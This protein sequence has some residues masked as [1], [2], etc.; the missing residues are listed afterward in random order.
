MDTTWGQ[1]CLNDWLHL[2]LAVLC[3]A[4]LSSA[5]LIPVTLHH[6]TGEIGNG[7]LNE[8]GWEWG[9]SLYQVN[10]LSLFHEG[11]FLEFDLVLLFETW[12]SVFLI[13][14]TL[15]V[16]FWALDTTVTFPS[17]DQ[18][19]DNLSHSAGPL[20]LVDPQPLWLSKALLCSLA[21]PS[22]WGCAKIHFHVGFFSFTQC[23]GVCSASFWISSRG[24]CCTCSCRFGV[25]IS[26]RFGVSKFRSFLRHCLEPEPPEWGHK[27]TW[28]LT[29]ESQVKLVCGT[30]S[31]SS[32]VVSIKKENHAYH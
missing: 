27:S 2:N 18:S 13:S 31:A 24:N 12:S 15:Y 28:W 14:L 29:L 6:E 10:H 17:L 9:L 7:Q 22:C 30:W 16:G 26:C 8:H 21:A 11:L 4:I 3:Y 19:G 1:V 23:V 5:R 25:S 20:L 32:K